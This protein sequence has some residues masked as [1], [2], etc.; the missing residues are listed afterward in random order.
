ML[1]AVKRFALLNAAM[2]VLVALV[3][4]IWPRLPTIATMDDSLGRV[5]AGLGANL[6]LLCVVL[7]CAHRQRRPVFHILTVMAMITT[8]AFLWIRMQPYGSSTG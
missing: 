5:F 2:A 4:A 7:A 3:M 6:G 1:Q 8:G